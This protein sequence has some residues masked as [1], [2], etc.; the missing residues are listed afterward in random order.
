MTETNAYDFMMWYKERTPSAKELVDYINDVFTKGSYRGNIVDIIS[1]YTYHDKEN[2]T[3]TRDFF[4]PE[5]DLIE[6]V[7]GNEGSGE[8][9]CYTVHFKKVDVY[10]KIEGEYASYCGSEFN[11]PYFVATPQV[12]TRVVYLK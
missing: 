3:E 10:I 8:Y 2:G 4:D 7:G 12:Q 11:H 6:E 5:I 1:D 9:T